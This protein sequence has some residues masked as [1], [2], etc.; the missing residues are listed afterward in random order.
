MRTRLLDSWDHRF[1]MQHRTSHPGTP[2]STPA[3]HFTRPSPGP[4]CL[5]CCALRF[6]N[7]CLLFALCKL[8]QTPL[9]LHS[10]IAC[11]PPARGHHLRLP[12]GTSAVR[13][14]LFPL[15]L[16]LVIACCY[17]VCVPLELTAILLHFLSMCTEL[18]V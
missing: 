11:L 7:L 18:P 8:A 15:L 3:P 10:T 9:L 5:Q 4:W 2:P 6:S 17:R 16:F 12:L 1:R 14:R 13:F